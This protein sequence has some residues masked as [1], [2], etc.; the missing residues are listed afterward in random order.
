MPPIT[1]ANGT[2][3]AEWANHRNSQGIL[4]Q[5]IRKLIYATIDDAQKVD[6]PSGEAIQLGGYDGIVIAEHGNSFV[7]NGTS[8][9][10]IGVNRS[11]KQK[12]DDDYN[13]RSKDSLGINP[14]QTTFIFISPRRWGGKEKWITKHRLEKIWHDVIVYDADDIEQWLELAPSVHVWFSILLGKHLTDAIDLANFWDQWRRTNKFTIPAEFLLAGRDN[15]G[16]VICEWAKNPQ[17]HLLLQADTRKEA[18]LVFCAAIQRMEKELSEFINNRT[19]I[20]EDLSTWRRVTS[21]ETPL[22]L[23]PMFDAKGVISLALKNQHHLFIPRG[24]SDQVSGDAIKIPRLSREKAF[25]T[26]AGQNLPDVVAK[27]LALLAR[28]SFAS[29]C[30][31]IAVIPEDLTPKWATFENTQSLLPLFFVSQWDEIQSGDRHAIEQ[32]SNST[33]DN[34]NGHVIKW[35]NDDDPP[36]RRIGN[37]HYFISK[38]EAWFLFSK[39]ITPADLQ[40]LHDCTIKVLS[41]P[42]PVFNLPIDEQWIASIRGVTSQYSKEIRKGLADTLALIG[43]FAHNTHL[44]VEIDLQAFVSEIIKQILEK[45]NKNW[46]IWATLSMDLP[47]FAEAAPELF[48]DMVENG[49]QNDSSE[50]MKIFLDS[51]EIFTSSPHPGLLWALETLAWDPQYLTQTAIVLSRLARLDPGGK[52][53]NRPLNSLSRIFLPW[54]PQTKAPIELRLKIFDI[55][56]KEEPEIAWK[57]MTSLLPKMHDNTTQIARPQWR[58]WDEGYIEGALVSDRNLQYDEILNRCFSDV[59]TNVIR[60]KE[61]INILPLMSQEKFELA[62]KQL[63]TLSEGQ[64]N[65]GESE[66]IWSSLRSLISWCRSYPNGKKALTEEQLEQLVILYHRFEP[67]NLLDKYH[68]LFTY[69]PLL[70]EG[71]SKDREKNSENIQKE[72]EKALK[73]IYQLQ[74]IDGVI[75]LAKTLAEPE[76]LGFVLGRTT[77]CI[78]DDEENNLLSHCLDNSVLW[79]RFIKGFINGRIFIFNGKWGTKKIK[80]KGQNWTH[81]Q[82]GEF[83]CD[84]GSNQEIWDLVS[85]DGSETEKEYWEHISPFTVPDEFEEYVVEMLLKYNRPYASINLIYHMVTGGQAISAKIIEKAISKFLQTSS[86]EAPSY[87]DMSYQIGE[88]LDFLYNSKEIDEKKIANL[89]WHLLPVLSRQE[90]HPRVLHNELA[91]NPEFFIEVVSSAFRGKGE[92]PKGLSKEEQYRAERSFELLH[93]WRTMPGVGVDGN[94]NPKVLRDWIQKSRSELQK[95][96][97]LSIC[98]DMIGQMLSSSPYE[99]DGSWPLKAIR[100]IVEALSSKEIEDGIIAGIINSRGVTS[101]R[102][103]D[104]GAQEHKL[105]DKYSSLAEELGDTWPRTSKLLRN[106]AENYRQYAIHEDRDDELMEDNI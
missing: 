58:D 105:A 98:D 2:D 96:G 84:L 20:I 71:N 10:E 94:L 28:R 82:R 75:E 6:F 24:A 1:Y 91:R 12:A 55:L 15:V 73:A 3:I 89:E 95:S 88:L 99:S 26:I 67:Q 9:W 22:F 30:R 66:T 90:R 69:T 79:S 103:G 106:L 80:D 86:N 47:L 60:W 100:D 27:E 35:L 54:Y 101:R 43:T 65:S 44:S 102:P 21:T 68:W 11:V 104:G 23:V 39:F 97:R 50:V 48:L 37:I 29:F 25:Q 70:I 4:P 8:V 61:I 42:S 36:L 81:K 14:S 78:T 72:Q 59:G 77:A 31:E 34:I 57:L 85:E 33:W 38:K 64:L 93:S 32:L 62:N 45:A 87:T 40:R 74:G 19:L 83:L 13:K 18:V 46:K 5:L 56:R 49:L 92:K 76:L 52:L 51:N 41:T 63:K 17:Q 16:K 53:S 7:P